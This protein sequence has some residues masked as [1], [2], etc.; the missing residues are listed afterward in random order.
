MTCDATST[1]WIVINVR[2]AFD[3]PAAHA[4][5]KVFL[6]K[7]NFAPAVRL[8]SVHSALTNNPLIRLNIAHA[9]LELTRGGITISRSAGSSKR[10]SLVE[11]KSQ[12]LRY[13]TTTR[14]RDKRAGRVY[15]NYASGMPTS[16]TRT[17][18]RTTHLRWHFSI[19]AHGSADY[20][21]RE[22]QWN[23]RR[24]HARGN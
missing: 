16:G 18:A 10:R 13:V 9:R 17:H 24:S 19:S 1:H 5:E 23:T 15:R 2:F 6:N 4:R 11:P 3:S 7:F 22:N 12:S 14:G 21:H 8:R 20:A